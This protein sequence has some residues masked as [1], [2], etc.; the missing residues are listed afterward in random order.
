MLIESFELFKKKRLSFIGAKWFFTHIFIRK[1]L[2]EKIHRT[3]CKQDA[4][5][6][7][8]ANTLTDRIYLILNRLLNVSH[9][10][11]DNFDSC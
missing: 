1:S 2:Q 7:P 4:V 3:V 5:L 9:A 6:I 10:S 8:S 11:L